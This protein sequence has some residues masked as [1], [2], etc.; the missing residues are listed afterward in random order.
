MADAAP[1]EDPAERAAIN[2]RLWAHKIHEDSM[3]FQRGNLFLL[4][5]SL[6]AV[7]YSAT[8]SASGRE[9]AARVMCAFGIALTLTWLYVGHRHLLYDLSLQRRVA[10][11]LPDFAETDRTCRQRGLSALPC[12]VYGLPSLSIVMWVVLVFIT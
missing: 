3:L 6:L 11:R 1:D 5:Q 9:N 10:A 7:A 12:I 4:A 2:E 8:A